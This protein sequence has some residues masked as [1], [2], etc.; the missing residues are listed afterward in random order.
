M[1]ADLI[2]IFSL[3]ATVAGG[4]L[5][6]WVGVKVAIVVLSI[7]IPPFELSMP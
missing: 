4:L 7:A 5:G 6:G 2:P 3:L 1:N